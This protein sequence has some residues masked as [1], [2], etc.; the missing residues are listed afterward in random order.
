MFTVYILKDKDDKLYK[1][2]T[3]NLVRRLREHKCGK[4]RT[5]NRM[6][7]LEVVYTEEYKDFADARK[8]ELYFKSAA[9]RR[10]LKKVMGR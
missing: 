4:T 10:F 9:G 6:E 3:N 5:T 2:L 1:G 8:R 7:R